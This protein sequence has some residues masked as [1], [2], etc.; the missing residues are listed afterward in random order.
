[1]ADQDQLVE[2]LRRVTADLRTAR[3][4]LAAEQARRSEPIAV[5]GIGC[6]FPGGVRTPEDLW[7]LVAEGRDAVTGFPADRGWDLA[8]LYDP[9]PDAAGR[10]YTREGGFL[11]RV[12][13]FDH[14]FFGLSPREATAMDP[15]QRLLLETSWE[16]LERAG[17]DPAAL[18]GSATGVFTGVMHHDYGSRLANP[19]EGFEG[20]LVGGSAGS[21]AA[22]RVSYLMGFE[23]PAVTVDTACSSSLVTLHLA[24]QALR[25][26]ECDLALAGGAAVMS[27]PTFFVEY[28]RQRVL[29]ADGRCRSFA[30]DCDGTGWSEGVGVLVV[31]RL[32]DAERLGHPVLAVVRG[33]AVNQDGASN[34]F[35]APNG[36]SQE[37]LIRAALRQAG[38][39][40]AEVDVV[41]GHGT[42]TRLGDPIEAQALIATYGAERPEGRPLWLGSLKSNLGHAQ[43][44][45]GVAGVIKMVMA[46]RHGVLPR[47]L[48]A[49]HPTSRV[50]WSGGGVELLAEARPWDRGGH[51]RRAGVSSFG[52]SG[53]NAHVLI[54]EYAGEAPVESTVDETV[55]VL[56]GRTPA[57][58]RDQAAALREYLLAHPDAPLGAVA[59][60]VA[61]GRSRFAH[62]GAV[63]GDRAGLVAGLAEV[64]VVTAGP[65]RVAAVFTGQGSQ[66]PG[67]GRE[68]AGRFEVFSSALDE[69]CAEVDPLLGRS[70]RDVMWSEP[71]EVL[72]RTEFSQPALFAFE[73]ALARLVE[74]WGVRFTAVAGHSV[75][76]FAAA[77]VSGVLS[78]TDAARLVVARGRLMQALPAGGA[79]L[80]VAAGVAEVSA[81]LADEPEVAIAAV[82]GPAAVVVSGAAAAVDRLAERWAGEYRT[83]PLRVDFAFHSPL[84]DPVLADFTAVTAGV[85]FAEATAVVH[86]SADTEH[87]FTSADYWVE[88]IRQAVRFDRTVA[89]LCESAEVDVVVEIGPDTALTPLFD[90]LLPAVACG[91]RAGSEVTTALSALGLAAAHGVAVDWAAAL[92]TGTALTDL[93]TYSFQREHHWLLDQPA[94]GAGGDGLRHPVLSGAV[95]LPGPG[96]VLLT[97]RISPSTDPWLADHAVFGSVL[98]PGAGFADLALT[99]ARHAGAAEVAELVVGAPLELPES[100][101]DVQVWIGPDGDLAIRARGGGGDWTTHATG[102]VGAEAPAVDA[103][104]V[105]VWPPDGAEAVPIDGLHADLARRGYA[106]GPAFRGLRAAWQ[107]DGDLFAEVEL[108]DD[109][110]DS[111]FAVH[112]AL[113]DATFH[114]LSAAEDSGRALLPFSFTRLTVTA[115]AT[116]LRVR[117]TPTGTGLRLDAVTPGGT[118]ALGIGELVL[119]PADP[120]S[121]PN[122]TSARLD[123]LRH[124][125][126]WQPVAP[127]AADTVPG[128][129][130]L[131]ADV[132]PSVFAESTS[133]LDGEFDGVVCAPANAEELLLTVQALDDAGVHAPLWC[134]TGN[135]LTDVDAAGTW[136][137]GRVI[138]LEHPDRWG[139]LVGVPADLDP[140]R[141]AGVLLGVEDQVL[142]TGDVVLARRLVPAAVQPPTEPWQP[143]GT[144]LITGGTGAL[145]GHVARLLA[146]RDRPLLLVSRRG[147]DA[148]SAGELLADLRERGANARIEAVDVAD[149]DAV[150]A[151][152]RAAEERGEPVRAV[153]H[154]AG[155]AQG[156]PVLATDVA[157]FRAT[158]SGKLT[159]ALVLDELLPD[160]DA[161]VVFSSISGIWGAGGQGAYATGNAAVD[162]VV[163]RRRAAG[164]PATALA[165]GPWAGG[166]MADAAGGALLRR[167]GLNEM[168]AKDAVL[169]F[170]RAVSLGTDAVLADVRWG[171]FLD[172]FTVGRPSP[173]L[174]DLALTPAAPAAAQRTTDV[175]GL[176]RT[177]IA[178]VIGQSDPERI[179]PGTPLRDL[180]FDSLMSVELRTRLAEAVGARLPATLVF[181]HPTAAA[182]A[183]HLDSLTAGSAVVG[184]T[185]RTAAGPV[186]EPIAIVGIGCRYPGGVSSP[187]D[188]WE[189]LVDGRDAISGFPA[190]RGWDLAR[191]YDPDPDRTGHSYTRDGGFLTAAADFDAEFFGI[192]PREALAMDPQHR[193]LLETAW[194]AVEAAGIDPG[195]L[196]GTRTGVFAGTMYNDY[197][198]RLAGTPDGLEGIIGIANSPSVLSGR[199]AYLL[200]LNGPA[201]T[202]DT[203]CSSSLVALHLAAQAL[204]AGECDLALAGGATVMASP[205]VFIEFARQGALSP[206]GRC[207]SF[208][209]GADGTGWSEGAG[210]LVVERLSDAR[211]RGHHVLAV[212]RGSAVNSDG[213]S[214]GLTAPNGPAQRRVI[215]DAL[216]Q[217]RLGAHE[218]AAVEAHG[219]GT[220]LGDPIEAQALMDVYGA[221]RADEPLWLGSLKS[222]LGHTQ[223]AAGVGGVIKMVMAMRNGILPRTLHAARPTAEVDWEGSGVALLDSPRPWPACDRPRVAG[224]SSF[225]VS[226]TNAHVVIAEGDP[227]PERRHE[228]DGPVPVLLSAKTASALPGQAAALREHLLARPELPL[229]DVAWSLLT[230]RSAFAHRSAVVADDRED[231]LADL[232]ALADPGAVTP[233]SAVTGEVRGG[234][235]GLVFPGQGSQWLGMARE[236]LV[237]SPVFAAAVRE[238]EEAF[239]GLVD[240]SLTEVLTSDDPDAHGGVDVV[241]PLLFAVMVGLA[242]MWQAWGVPVAAVVGH[243]Q[244]E[245]A[246][247]CASGA[248]STRDAARVV[249]TRSRLLRG[250]TGASGMASVSMPVAELAPRLDPRLSVAAVNGPRGVVVSGPNDALDALAAE[251]EAEGVRVRRVDVDYASHSAEVESVRDRLLAELADIEPRDAQVPLYSTVTGTRLAGHELDAA[252]WYRNLR[253]T[254]RFQD[255]VELM[256][257]DGFGFFVESSP[258]PVLAVG[259]RETLD[260]EV[261]LGSLRR[262]SG[263]LDRML[264]SLTEGGVQGLPVDWSAVLPVGTPVPLPTYAFHRTRYWID[265]TAV[266][267]AQQSDV[268]SRF[269]NA[270]ESADLSQLGG[271]LDA[272]PGVRAVLP[273]LARWR[274]AERQRAELD[275][276]RYTVAWRDQAVRPAVPAGRWLVVDTG[277]PGAELVRAALAGAGLDTARLVLDAADLDRT[278]L[279]ARISAEGQLAGVLCLVGLDEAPHPDIPGVTTGLALAVTAIQ[280]LDTPLWVLTTSATEVDGPPSHPLQQQLWGL[281]RVAALEFPERWAGLLDL[282]ED[283]DPETATTALGVLA[284]PGEDD[285]WAVRGAKASVRRLVRLAPAPAGSDYEPTGTVLITGAG[286]SLGPHLARSAAARGADCVVLL[287]RRGERSP[288]VAELVAEL[289][290]GGTRVRV[291]DCD[292]RD[293]RRLRAVLAELADEGERVTTVLHAAAHLGIEPLATTT[294]TRFAEV[295]DAKVAGAVHLAELLDRRYLRKLVLFSS[296]AGVWGSADH[297][298]Y[299]AG[300]A[301]LDAYAQRLRADGLPATTIAWGIWD[302][303]ITVGRTDAERVVRRG[304]PFIAPETALAGLWQALGEDRPFLAIADVDWPTFAPVFT[305]ARRSPLLAELPEAAPPVPEPSASGDTAWRA[306]LAD[307]TA[308]DRERAALDLVRASAGAVLG[309]GPGEEPAS[310]LP[311]RNAGFD[312][313]LSVE[314]RNRLSAATGLTLPPTVV[315]DH[316]TPVELA[317]HLLARVAEGQPARAAG[318]VSTESVLGAL[319]RVEADLRALLSGADDPDRVRLAGRLDALVAAVRPVEDLDGPGLADTASTEELLELLDRRFGDA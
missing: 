298:A 137:L 194:E 139:G 306:G 65:G 206:D 123:A 22:G 303:E 280:A 128:C 221:G 157:H 218:V 134:L 241:Q 213:A 57:A 267:G 58:V 219:T 268:D 237:A 67:M 23:G 14:E 30:E 234:R 121:L 142:I 230:T 75:G 1:M 164:K 248:L 54:E 193:L 270:V 261:V 111:R 260:T 231:L 37:R 69:V 212:L 92:G 72:R 44:A 25:A 9:D 173:L 131:L 7:R 257:A 21:A 158:L 15:Q 61:T 144:V 148:P 11:D 203:A 149:R 138:A 311:F 252:Y 46:M 168:P 100:G 166:G 220:R 316:A 171:R 13:R 191:L 28:S 201:V 101:V 40:A 8:R 159:G 18:R 129:W 163:A 16:A 102:V 227:V 107:R 117:L 49:E 156:A 27:T 17:L 226:G 290:A 169:A 48:Y 204:R 5:V 310:G 198:S 29:S 145:G 308:A 279:T 118:A 180:G 208:A 235:V 162:A 172:A 114:V 183:A 86:P 273:A 233:A 90:G 10:S 289:G 140:V 20:F 64:P 165:W 185:T 36:P 246:A 315:F 207:K 76:E 275:G 288:G 251:F 184:T 292:V 4:R 258:H 249:I 32:S 34:G 228:S 136:G 83:S 244:G 175:L 152:L 91:R 161:F 305:S 12:D 319:D 253:D 80:A 133:N 176:V 197:F 216:A 135:D 52:M 160:L 41:E 116:A 84:V 174:A 51:P 96:G 250:L 187:D 210:V 238:C 236:L 182:L 119:R 265:A 53:T 125:V 85:R 314:L 256:A 301:F 177:H 196:H 141:L 276:W 232:G 104:W 291:F 109:R 309:L 127:T 35:T 112:P 47:S 304:L 278:R 199:I 277:I 99:A 214:N 71:A 45:A 26:G 122:G 59:R 245:I 259:L 167:M 68:L 124:E 87:P 143:S 2:Y 70:L 120:E 192:S 300:N 229:A 302:D 178:A 62:R 222:N 147:I 56:S 205:S 97:G 63:A 106:Y 247:A 3:S 98:Y 283:V 153:V 297:A 225:G 286:G 200:G 215:Q 293:R 146:D 50:D 266:A 272:V 130:L 108:P 24:V 264:R 255:A 296:V 242:R 95:D 269:W 19:P 239:T 105:A 189:L 113:L 190:D 6:R 78:L 224:V 263:G 285:Q 77:V 151:L 186:G 284:A 150:A 55:L 262:N 132:D 217:A 73:I 81:A 110:H 202:V 223:A 181:D 39:P 307:L 42:G 188:L 287:S 295:V 240:W 126:T 209:D 88:H 243:S 195:T 74:S 318:P 179:D 271:D 93:P 282:P 115:P 38:I 155:V 31:E 170:D 312:S 103:Q 317:A 60:T 66:R 313:L 89:A 299:A 33:S 94:L 281:G 79:M 274:R 154:A 254:V 294:H 82:N 43:A 211:A